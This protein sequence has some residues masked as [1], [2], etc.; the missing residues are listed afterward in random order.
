MNRNGKSMMNHETSPV[1]SVII[2]THNRAHVIGRAIESVLHQSYPHFEIVVVDDGSTDET[3]AV[4][5]NYSD[6]RVVYLWQENQERSAARNHGIAA[7]RGRYI[8]FLDSDD[9]F[10]PDKLAVQL[11]ILKANPAIGMVIGGWSMMND[12]GNIISTACPWEKIPGQPSVEDWLFASVGKLCALLIRK[13]HLIAATGFD[14]SMSQSEDIEL[15]I[16]LTLAG[17]TIG[18]TPQTV[19]AG[20]WHTENSL[21]NLE[22]VR[23]GRIA[24]LDKLFT[25]PDFREHLSLSQNQVYAN[26]Y[27][28]VACYQ[29]AAKQVNDAQR[30]LLTAVKLDPDLLADDGRCLVQK[31]VDISTSKFIEDPAQYI[32]FLFENLPAPLAG[33]YRYKRDALAEIWAIQAFRAYQQSHWSSAWKAAWQAARLNIHWLQNRG[34]LSIS[35]RALYRSLKYA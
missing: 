15:M 13:E 23:L 18:W 7:S 4:V 5:A 24:M 26:A 28:T 20:L 11:P 3:K 25:R 30:N 31:C 9:W 35:I 10:L 6:P 2:P 33:L 32:E 8:A 14:Q 19:A 22:K 27:F 29:F 16:R 21:R 12:Q 34:L 17:L 1:V